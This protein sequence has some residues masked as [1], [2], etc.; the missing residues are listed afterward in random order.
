MIIVIIMHVSKQS[1]Q[2]C[3]LSVL[4]ELA[5][6]PSPSLSRPLARPVPRPDCQAEL[7]GPAG[8]LSWLAGWAG[9]AG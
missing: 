4:A 8:R 6:C 1:S 2:M 5:L 9:W 3:A 7:A